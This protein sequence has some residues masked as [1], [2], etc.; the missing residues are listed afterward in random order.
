[1]CGGRR[2]GRRRKNMGVMHVE[3]EISLDLERHTSS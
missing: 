3:V 2:K 1:M